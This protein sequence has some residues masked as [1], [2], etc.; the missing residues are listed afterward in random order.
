MNNYEMVTILDPGLDSVQFLEKSK[1]IEDGIKSFGGEIQNISHWGKR[2]FAYDIK[3][4]D[5]GYYV[6]INFQST[7]KGLLDFKDSIRH[8]LEILRYLIIVL[9]NPPVFEESD[10]LRETVVPEAEVVSSPHVEEDLKEKD[11]SPE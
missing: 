1:F 2:K 9:K 3:K 7:P 8:D 4:K 10:T 6:V 5:A 11:L